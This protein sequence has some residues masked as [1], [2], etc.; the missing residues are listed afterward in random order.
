MHEGMPPSAM[1]EKIRA[2]GIHVNDAAQAMAAGRTLRQAILD[3]ELDLFAIFPSRDTPIRLH[4]QALIEAAFPSDSAVLTFIYIDRHPRAPFGLSWSYL[5][6]LTRDPLCVEERAFRGWMRKQERRKSWPCHQEEGRARR[7]RG[8][9]SDLMGRVVEVIEE[10]HS[11]GKLTPSMGNKEVQALVQKSF[12]SGCGPSI[13]T[14]RLARK[15]VE[16]SDR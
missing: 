6:E 11:S 10:L 7:S 5:K 13:E 12:P 3:G 16:I 14:V 15:E 8:R 2:E 9:P 1:I 4:D